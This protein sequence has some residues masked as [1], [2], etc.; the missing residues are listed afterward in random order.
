MSIAS[1]FANRS[2]RAA[3]FRQNKLYLVISSEFTNGRSV[4]EIFEAACAGGIRLIQL[5]EKNRGAKFLYE[6]ARICRKI[7]NKY[8]TLMMIDDMLDAALL[9]GADGVH[10]GQDDLPVSAARQLTPDLLL[11]CSTHDLPEALAACAEDCDYINIG[12]IYA[13]ATKTHLPVPPLG[14]ENLRKIS[15]AIPQIPFSVMGG[16]KQERFGELYAHGARLFA[17]VTEITRAENVEQ[18]VKE[19]LA[20]YAAAERGIKA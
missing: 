13:T 11:G 20:A 7:A 9:S 17:M 2:E 16:I 3:A 19:L 8:G 1:C 18:K 5:R 4:P 10:L 14:P 6:Q 15:S 12:P